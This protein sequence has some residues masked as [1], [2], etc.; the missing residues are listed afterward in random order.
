MVGSEHWFAAATI[1]DNSGLKAINK[2]L[3]WDY[4]QSRGKHNLDPAVPA[5]V[6]LPLT[7]HQSR[8]QAE[9]RSDLLELGWSILRLHLYKDEFGNSDTTTSECL[10]LFLRPIDSMARIARFPSAKSSLILRPKAQLAGTRKT[11]LSLC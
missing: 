5:L 11:E 10:L 9:K 2:R 1:N 7:R 3:L 8:L 6:S 4:S